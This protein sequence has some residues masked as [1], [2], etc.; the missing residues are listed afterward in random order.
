[1]EPVIPSEDPTERPIETS[2]SDITQTPEAPDSIT[3]LGRYKG[4]IEVK[5]AVEDNKAVFTV[6]SLIDTNI[7]DGII[8][9]AAQYDSTGKMMGVKIVCGTVSNNSLVIEAD[10]P[11][12]DKYKFMMWDKDNTPVIKVITKI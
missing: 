6:N 10:I 2:K 3:V 8:L 12:S 11:T 1:M 5:K 4:N 9:F 7:L